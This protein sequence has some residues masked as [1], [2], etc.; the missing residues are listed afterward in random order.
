MLSVVSVRCPVYGRDEGLYSYAITGCG[1]QSSHVPL[2]SFSVCR[3]PLLLLLLLLRAVG[4]CVAD[5]YLVPTHVSNDAEFYYPVDG[6]NYIG[7]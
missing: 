6:I 5:L 2:V 1:L 7:S 4:L 3:L